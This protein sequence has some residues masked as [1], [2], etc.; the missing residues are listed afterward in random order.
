M[1]I[2]L[3]IDYTED[4]VEFYDNGLMIIFTNEDKPNK[5]YKFKDFIDDEEVKDK[6][7]YIETI[8]IKCA[9]E[10]YYINLEQIKD[11]K[12]LEIMI[13]YME[14]IKKYINEVKHNDDY[15]N[16]LVTERLKKQLE[17]L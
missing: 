11:K 3:D 17:K 13:E 10:D 8:F 12:I 4:L 5:A 6:I 14:D 15:I 2:R 1:E 16:D 9:N 7:K